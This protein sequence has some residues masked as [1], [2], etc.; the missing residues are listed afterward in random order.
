MRAIQFSPASSPTHPA[1]Q[2]RGDPLD[3]RIGTLRGGPVG[4]RRRVSRGSAQ[5]VG[6]PDR[7][8]VE[9]D[10]VFRAW[11][12]GGRVFAFDARVRHTAAGDYVQTGDL[13]GC[14]HPLPS[15]E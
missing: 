6:P 7:G 2:V 13:R 9:D 15:D 5:A 8:G 10:I 11:I 3:S 12:E 1:E 4:R 14:S